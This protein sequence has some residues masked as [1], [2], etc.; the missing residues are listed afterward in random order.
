MSA[1]SSSLSP[2]SNLAGYENSSASKVSLIELSVSNCCDAE[3]IGLLEEGSA[4]IK[5]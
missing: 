1:F 4:R 5:W 3:A 2:L